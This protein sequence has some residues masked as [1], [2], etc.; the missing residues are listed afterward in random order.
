M[1]GSDLESSRLEASW[2]SQCVMSGRWGGVGCCGVGYWSM[3]CWSMRCWG[4]SG[5]SC[6]IIALRGV[7]SCMDRS[8]DVPVVR[9][10]VH[11]A[12]LGRRLWHDQG[13]LVVRGRVVRL[14]GR[15]RGRSRG[16]DR[17]RSWSCLGRRHRSRGC[18]FRSRG[19]LGRR[20]RSLC[21]LSNR[22]RRLGFHAKCVCDHS[23]CRHNFI[24]HLASSMVGILREVSVTRVIVL[25]I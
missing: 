1:D 18:G 25:L 19:S 5:R 4:M 2:A 3:R 6:S 22:L 13:L 9:R 17:S 10:S 23:I 20:G 7:T 24:F 14:H 8:M 11:G 15:S 21:R 16:L 12:L